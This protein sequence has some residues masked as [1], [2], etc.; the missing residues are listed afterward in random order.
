MNFELNSNIQTQPT[1]EQKLSLTSV[2]ECVEGKKG[3]S[4]EARRRFGHGN[5]NTRVDDGRKN[6]RARLRRG[7]VR[8]VR[9]LVVW[10]SGMEKKTPVNPVNCFKELIS[11]MLK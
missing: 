4:L 9:R 10:E 1:A 5:G 11:S 2:I 8:S 7:D 6:N 3:G